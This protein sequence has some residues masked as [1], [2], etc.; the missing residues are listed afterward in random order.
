VLENGAIKTQGKFNELL[1]Q[2]TLN[3]FT[4]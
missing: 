3:Q 4:A 1:K 2:G